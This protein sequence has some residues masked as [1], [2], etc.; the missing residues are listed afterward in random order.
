[1]N[2][3]EGGLYRPLVWSVSAFLLAAGVL[4]S[5]QMVSAIVGPFRLADVGAHDPRMAVALWRPLDAASGGLLRGAFGFEL[6]ESGRSV[7]EVTSVAALDPARVGAA[8][9]TEPR[10]LGDAEF[11]VLERY[12]ADGGG[13]VVLGSVAV[14]DAEGG[15]RGRASMER[16]LGARVVEIGEAEAVLV[17]AARGPISAPL[18]PR[19][20]IEVSPEPGMP[21]LAGV[22]GAELRWSDAADAPAAALRREIGAGRLVW[23]AVPPERALPDEAARRAVRTVVESSLAWA[24][25]TPSV[26]V[27]PWPSGA[28]YAV[29]VTASGPAD[30]PSGAR[31]WRE[32][33]DRAARDGALATLRV[34][35]GSDAHEALQPELSRVLAAARRDQAWVATRRDLSQW[36]RGRGVVDATLRRAGPRRLVIEVSN[37]FRE[38]MEGVVLRIHTNEPTAR[39]TVEGTTLGQ[40]TAR[41]RRAADSESIDLLLPRIAARTNLSWS[42][43]FETEA[44]DV[45]KRGD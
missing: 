37:R 34:P 27:L 7:R 3:P 23:I 11:A 29:V 20:R 40:A 28:P 12:V 16:L 32:T 33:L 13:V 25:R 44:T 42:V 1:V 38:P 21:G 8:V 10:R 22:A 43:D 41:A 4:L 5:I 6:V 9:L 17:A 18:E 15:W 24:S 35:R 45:A 30:A 31:E 19:R 36:Q 26:E 2:A 14:L 39:A